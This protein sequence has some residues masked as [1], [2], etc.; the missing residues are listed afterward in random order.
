MRKR[1]I[2][3]KQRSRWTV[4]EWEKEWDLAMTR[5]SGV[6]TLVEEQPIYQDCLSVLNGAFAEG[7]RLRFAIGLKALMDFCTEAVNQGDCD[8]WWNSGDT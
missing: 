6:P 3:V 7:N 4:H 2:C 1:R 5:I 8:P